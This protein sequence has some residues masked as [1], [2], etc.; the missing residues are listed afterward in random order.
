MASLGLSRKFS[1]SNSCCLPAKIEVKCNL[2][3]KLYFLKLTRQFLELL[4]EIP[5]HLKLHLMVAVSTRPFIVATVLIP[6]RSGSVPVPFRVLYL[7]GTYTACIYRDADRANLYYRLLT[8]ISFIIFTLYT[9]RE[10][11]RDY[12]L[13]SVH[14]HVYILCVM[15]VTLQPTTLLRPC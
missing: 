2:T 7:P 6:F 14:V 11:E 15:H 13:Y 12:A 4:H 8:S 1:R 9:E 3:N 10:R 5:K